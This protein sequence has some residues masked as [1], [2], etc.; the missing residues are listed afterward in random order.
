MTGATAE[1]SAE[2][3]LVARVGSEYFAFPI[4]DV[5]EAL[6][7]PEV[8]PV[9]LTPDG[10]LGQVTHRGQLLPVLDPHVLLG[11]DLA[12]RVGARAATPHGTVLV[13][14]PDGT[15]FALAVD[16]VT[17]M[18]TVEPAARR[19]LPEGTDRTGMLAGLFAIDRLLVASV[20]IAALR[21]NAGVLL[22]TGTR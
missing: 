5:L 6:D 12:T 1:R 21:A 3:V 22:T 2:R 16:D 10:V 19:A 14:V 9:P 18:V 11:A 20:D 15:P 8:T 13:M 17:D 7:A 4:G